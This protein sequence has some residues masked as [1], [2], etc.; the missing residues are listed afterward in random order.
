M[1]SNSFEKVL[2]ESPGSKEKLLD[3]WS[4]LSPSGDW[5]EIEG[6]ETVIRR[7]I[8]NLLISKGSYMFDPEYGSNIFKFVYEPADSVTYEQLRSE[9]NRVVMDN[10]GSVNVTSEVLFFKNQRGFRINI[11]V[12]TD[13]GRIKKIPLD[14]NETLLRE[15]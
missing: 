12:D 9:I 7:I 8:T 2:L 4:I 6:T 5:K 1:A 11:I 10:K 14:I 15:M 13:N 3:I